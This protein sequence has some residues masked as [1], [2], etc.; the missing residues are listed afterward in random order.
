MTPAVPDS[1]LGWTHAND[2]VRAGHSLHCSS[3]LRSKC[4]PRRPARMKYGLECPVTS[5]LKLPGEHTVSDSEQTITFTPNA[6]GV[7]AQIKVIAPVRN[8]ASF[9]TYKVIDTEHK[10]FSV[11]VD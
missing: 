11:H 1:K 4:W 2:S 6:S 7:L 8:P 3:A 9:K 5:R 10:T